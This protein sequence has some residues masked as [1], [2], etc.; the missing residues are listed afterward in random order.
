MNCF[1]SKLTT[2]DLSGLVGDDRPSATSKA[3][4]HIALIGSDSRKGLDDRYGKGL[5]SAQSDTLLVPHLSADRKGAT[6]V[7][8]TLATSAASRRAWRP[9]PTMPAASYST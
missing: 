9:K 2:A 1:N 6:V 7:S 3:L 5:T 4:N 8:A